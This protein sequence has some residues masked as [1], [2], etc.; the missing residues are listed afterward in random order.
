MVGAELSFEAGMWNTHDTAQE[1]DEEVDSPRGISILADV[2]PQ[3]H[4]SR[5]ALPPNHDFT[6][7]PK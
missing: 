3:R 6:T 7:R 2:E 5:L 4:L 1:S